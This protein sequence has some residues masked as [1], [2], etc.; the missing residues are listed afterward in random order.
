MRIARNDLVAAVATVAVLVPAFTIAAPPRRAAKKPAKTNALAADAD[1]PTEDATVA[2]V[3]RQ[4]ALVARMTVKVVHPDEVRGALIKRV[5]KDGG[6]PIL[7]TDY[8]LHIKLPPAK[9]QAF[10]KA[11]AKHGH[12]LDKHMSRADLTESIAQLEG[13]VRSKSEILERLRGFVDDSNVGATLKI[14]REMMRLV[15]ELERVKGRLQIERDRATWA[16][17]R[18]SFRYKRRGRMTYVRS[19]FK[20]LNT[21]DVNRFLGS[22]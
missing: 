1:T 15:T 13:K 5:K 8:A 22:F 2:T 9:L 11:A 19:P 3:A 14:E 17:L 16:L 4:T 20:W 7:V 10:M 21:V 6:F 12:V 18:L